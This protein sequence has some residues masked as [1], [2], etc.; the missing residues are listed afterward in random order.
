MNSQGN[1]SLLRQILTVL[2][3]LAAGYGIGNADQWGSIANDIAVAV[4]VLVSAGS[5]M[6]SVW[7]HYKQVKVPEHTEVIPPSYPVSAASVMP[8]TT[9][10]KAGLLP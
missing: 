9:A 4:P 6:W 2:G 5:I 3:G 1:L 7:A 8:A 10:I